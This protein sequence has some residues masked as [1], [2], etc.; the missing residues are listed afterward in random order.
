[1]KTTLAAQ[2]KLEQKAKAL[3]PKG[4]VLTFNDGETWMVTKVI[5]N[6]SNPQGYLLAPYGKTKEYYI[7]MQIEFSIKKLEDDLVAVN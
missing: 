2:L 5:G 6:S 4:A 3:F 1:M 7:S